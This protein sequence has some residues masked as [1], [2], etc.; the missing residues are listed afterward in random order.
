MDSLSPD[1]FSEHTALLATHSVSLSQTPD[2]R[3]FYSIFIHFLSKATHCRVNHSHP[4]H[5][6][7]ILSF[8]SAESGF[9]CITAESG[10]T[11]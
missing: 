10:H 5:T 1:V 3:V 6:S 4:D 7:L 11:H 9:T 2:F 8:I